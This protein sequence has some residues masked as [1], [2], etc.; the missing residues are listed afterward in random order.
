MRI[1]IAI[2]VILMLTNIAFAWNDCP[3]GRVNCTYPGECGRYIDTNNNG[4]CDHSEPAPTTNE[5]SNNNNIDSQTNTEIEITDELINEYVNIPGKEL[6]KYTIKEIC[7]KY[8][9]NPEDLEKKLKINVPLD[10]TIEEIKERYGISPSVVKR[11][12]V[13]CLIDEGKIKVENNNK[14]TNTTAKNNNESIIDK[15]ISFLFST[16]NLRDLLFGWLNG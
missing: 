7:E 5:Q 8:N 10:T 16:I 9:I 4:I 3:F 15:I 11:A 1:A 12:I 6:K 13:E 14:I 2:I